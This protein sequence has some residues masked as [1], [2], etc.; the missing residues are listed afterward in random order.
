MEKLI[1]IFP[2]AANVR[3]SYDDNKREYGFA[4]HMACHMNQRASVV[5][6]LIKINPLAL[7]VTDSDGKYEEDYYPIH[8]AIENNSFDSHFSLIRYMMRVDPLAV[9]RQTG[10]GDSPLRMACEDDDFHPL[11]ESMLKQLNVKVNMRN[12]RGDTPLH[13]ACEIGRGK[14]VEKLLQ[15]PDIDVNAKDNSEETPLYKASIHMNIDIVQQ[16]LDHPFIL[17]NEKNRNNNECSKCKF[18]FHGYRK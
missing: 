4:L 14:I 2:K 7:Q 12:N 9:Q 6:K 1:E 8:S 3:V 16:L 15:H 17:I 5:Y 11:V 18:M 10:D 13:N